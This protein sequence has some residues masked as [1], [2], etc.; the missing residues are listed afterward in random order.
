MNFK[1]LILC[2]KVF[3]SPSN[4]EQSPC[5]ILEDFPKL[6]KSSQPDF[7]LLLLQGSNW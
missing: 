2:L 1:I 3:K 6:P 4:C 5:G 7:Q